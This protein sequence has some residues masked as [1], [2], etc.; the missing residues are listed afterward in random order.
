MKFSRF[1]FPQLGSGG[2]V[3]LRSLETVAEKVMPRFDVERAPDP[4]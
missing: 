1:G 3:Q 2:D 4:S